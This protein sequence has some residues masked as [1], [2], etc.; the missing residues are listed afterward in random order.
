[1]TKTQF[2]KLLEDQLGEAIHT[3]LRKAG[4]S[5]EARQAHSAISAMKS[6]EWARVIDF[7]TYGM[8]ASFEAYASKDEGQ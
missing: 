6:E 5:R 3:S 8:L 2:E 7:A 4:E 1:M